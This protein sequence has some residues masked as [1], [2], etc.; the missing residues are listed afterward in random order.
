MRLKGRCEGFMDIEL[1]N[2]TIYEEGGR[3]GGETH[4]CVSD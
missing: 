2:S 4:I 1:E 3:R